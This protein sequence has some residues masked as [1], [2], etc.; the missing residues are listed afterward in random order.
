M[1][2]ECQKH[3]MVTDSE[4]IQFAR[5]GFLSVAESVARRSIKTSC[6]TPAP[7]EYI[8]THDDGRNSIGFQSNPNHIVI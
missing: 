2:E 1:S 3:K 5:P 6:L 7:G 4:V 8:P